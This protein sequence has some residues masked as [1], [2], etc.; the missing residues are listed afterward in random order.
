MS[1]MIY[2]TNNNIPYSWKICRFGKLKSAKISYSHIYVWRS[3]QILIPANISGY[4]VLP[5]IVVQ[6]SV[7]HAHLYNI[8]HRSEFLKEKDRSKTVPPL[9]AGPSTASAAAC[10]QT[11]INSSGAGSSLSRPQEL[12]SMS[13]TPQIKP[14]TR[15]RPRDTS[16]EFFSASSKVFV[17]SSSSIEGDC[18]I[19]GGAV[20]SEAV[21]VSLEVKPYVRKRKIKPKINEKSTS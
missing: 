18:S 20:R 11:S 16:N 6:W 10:S 8:I 13:S 9:S 3:H 7:I 19:G 21:T 14:Y 4:T 15:K 12:A 17:P 1:S 5:F 2:T